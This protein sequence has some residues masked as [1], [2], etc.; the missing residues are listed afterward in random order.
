MKLSSALHAALNDQIAREF[1]AHF[2]YRAI[3]FDL[4]E[5]GYY[6][7][8]AWMENHAREEY[9]HAERIINYLKEKNARV[10]LHA[11]EITN[12]NWNGPKAA[13]EAALAHEEWLTAEIHK[14]HDQASAENDKTS[15]LLLDWF[16][17]EQQEEEKVVGDLIKRMKLCD[18]SPVGLMILDSEL[19][20]QTPQPPEAATDIQE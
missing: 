13:V 16:V 9:G 17:E 8:S 2:L 12:K 7:F 14:L 3:A 10:S 5:K 18:F 20:T 1:T 19:T 4:Y 11:I 6:G 15:I